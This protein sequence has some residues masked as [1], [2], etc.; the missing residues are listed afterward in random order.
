MGCCTEP[1]AVHIAH[2]LQ[3]LHFFQVFNFFYNL[4]GLPQQK[5]LHPFTAK[6]KII[7]FFFIIYTTYRKKKI[8]AFT[9]KKKL[10]A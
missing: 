3:T 8:H 7:Q 1:A 6:K 10:H 9:A 2:V 4:H 5:K